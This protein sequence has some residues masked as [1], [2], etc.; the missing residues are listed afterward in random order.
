MY[1]EC[2]H[3]KSNG[4]K[5]HSPAM[6][7]KPYCYYHLRL[8]RII[9][10]RPQRSSTPY[11]H[12]DLQIPFLEDRGAVQIALSEVV[13]ALAHRSHRLQ[14]RSADDLRPAGRLLQRQNS[15]RSR[16]PSTGP[17]TSENEEGDELAPE[18]TTYEPDD[19]EYKEANHEPT[20][21]EILMAEVR[22]QRQEEEE[23][24]QTVSRNSKNRQRMLL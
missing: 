3:I 23:R 16:S 1:L 18:I 22:R 20:L 11:E 24:G 15:S 5:C 19:E 17:R 12:K 2:R 10:G 7:D 13:S 14:T 6:K 4:S 9:H 8:H 21:T